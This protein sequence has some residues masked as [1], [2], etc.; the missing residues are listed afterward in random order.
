MENFIPACMLVAIIIFAIVS[1][2]W[3]YNS[4]TQ[5]S[6]SVEDGAYNGAKQYFFGESCPVCRKATLE[7]LETNS[8]HFRSYAAE[9]SSPYKLVCPACK[10]EVEG[11]Y[12]PGVLM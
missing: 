3:S 1:V 9:A 12:Y 4:F 8:V 2:L 5:S 10:N 11:V 6:K 7:Y